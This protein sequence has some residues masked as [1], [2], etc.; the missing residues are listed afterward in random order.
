MNDLFVIKNVRGLGVAQELFKSCEKFTKENG[1]AHMAWV[2]T[3][4]N[5]RAQKFY[6]KMGDSIGIGQIIQFNSRDLLNKGSYII[7]SFSFFYTVHCFLKDS[8]I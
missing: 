2:N 4:D 3:T 7:Y 8:A 6:E 1:Y 5:K